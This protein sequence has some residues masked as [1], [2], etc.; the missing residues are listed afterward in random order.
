MHSN[1]PAPFE[2]W[3]Q[4]AA[5]MVIFHHFIPSKSY[6]G[7]ELRDTLSILTPK[8]V[9]RIELLFQIPFHLSHDSLLSLSLCAIVC[10]SAPMTASFLPH[11]AGSWCSGQM[12]FHTFALKCGLKDC[13]NESTLTFGRF[14]IET[15]S[16]A[17]P[18]WCI[19]LPYLWTS[20]ALILPLFE[21]CLT[22]AWY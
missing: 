16:K 11:A 2:M 15:V 13:A 19:L 17:N 14:K 9:S 21:Y 18:L 12:Y 6:P 7:D 10:Q 3:P 22:P 20:P 8:K 4:R 5:N 1:V